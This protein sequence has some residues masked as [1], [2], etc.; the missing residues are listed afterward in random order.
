[1][2]SDMAVKRPYTGVISLIL[3]IDM[4]AGTHHLRV[5]TL[6]VRGVGKCLVG[7]EAGA[8]VEDGHYVAV[9][10]QGL[11]FLGKGVVS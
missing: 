3:H 11:E 5:S 1:M 6:R 2:P 10:V 8:F 9:D 4:P 7:V